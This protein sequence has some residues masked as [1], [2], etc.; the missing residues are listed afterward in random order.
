MELEKL[1]AQAFDASVQVQIWKNRYEQL[2]K[3]IGEAEQKENK[4]SDKKSE[5]KSAEQP[6]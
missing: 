5:E 2:L 6:K 4:K 3:L 1:K